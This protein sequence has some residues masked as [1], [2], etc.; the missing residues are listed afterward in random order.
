MRDKD[1]RHSQRRRSVRE[2]VRGARAIVVALGITATVA[3][4]IVSPAALGSR[5]GRV[6]TGRLSFVSLTP[7]A[8]PTTIRRFSLSTGRVLGVLAR[9]PPRTPNE[10]EV[11]NPHLLPDGHYLITFDHDVR[12][13]NVQSVECVEIPNTCG[14][15][16]E[17]LDPESGRFTLLFTEPGDVRVM[18]AIPSPDGD[19][20]AVLERACSNSSFSIVIRELGTG[21]QHRLLT[22]L[23]ACAATPTASWDSSGSHLLFATRMRLHGH[24]PRCVLAIAPARR[25]ST[26]AAWTVITPD[27]SCDIASAT[28]DADGIAVAEDCGST[29]PE[30]SSRLLQFSS[31]GRLLRRLSLGPVVE[32]PDGYEPTEVASDPRTGAVLVSRIAYSQP[33]ATW[34]WSFD[35]H[36][37]SLIHHYPGHDGVSAEP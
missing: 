5:S 1:G 24:S 17:N 13:R 15:R 7:I 37:L 19:L 4:L 35:G 3:V 33:E 22:H 2:V 11:Q 21:H 27:R 34:V 29:E 14:S 12:C 9:L 16:I 32:K 36:A 31:H 28:Y 8:A 20:A 26:P 25:P 10:S 18:D 23:Y 6:S 30:N